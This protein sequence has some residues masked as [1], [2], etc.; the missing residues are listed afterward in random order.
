[1]ARR[2]RRLVLMLCLLALVA[3]AE[4]PFRGTKPPRPVQRVEP[5]YTE[6]A[7]AEKVQGS[8]GLRARLDAEGRLQ[9]IRVVRSLGHGLDGK[10][11]ECVRQWVWQPAMRDGEEPVAVDVYVEVNFRL[12]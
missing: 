8:V 2:M 1:V 3:Q 5:Q 12:L 11:V 7:R 9:D 10:A 6:E 4:K